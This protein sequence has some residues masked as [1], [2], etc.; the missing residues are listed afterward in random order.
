MLN[1]LTKQYS[2]KFR[3]IKSNSTTIYFFKYRLILINFCSQNYYEFEL[4]LHEK[5]KSNY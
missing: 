4:T 2:T 1:V 3:S 5:L